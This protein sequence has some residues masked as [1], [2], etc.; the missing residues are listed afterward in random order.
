MS[1]KFLNLHDAYAELKDELD[2]A[3]RTVM[4]SGKYILGEQVE[5]FEE[6]FAKYCNTNACLGVANGQ[7]AL[8]LILRAYD[9]GADDEVIVPAHTFIATWLA[10]SQVGATPV[11]VE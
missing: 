4:K 7:E 1:V 9:I 11:P 3:Y 10:V 5:L 2:N 6:E 8:A